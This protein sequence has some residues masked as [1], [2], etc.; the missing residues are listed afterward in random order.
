MEGKCE[1]LTCLSRGEHKTEKGLKLCH[2]CYSAYCI[3]YKVGVNDTEK[4]L[5]DKVLRFFRG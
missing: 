5:V 3:G 1:T 4:I 2:L